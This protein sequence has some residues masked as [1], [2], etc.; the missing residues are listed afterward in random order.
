MLTL[1]N[2][3]TQT[4]EPFTASGKVALYVCGVT[5]YDTTHV[6]HA[7]VNVVFDVLVR[8]LHHR[9]I[10]ISYVQN[11]TDVDDSILQRAAELDVPYDELGDLYTS[12]YFDDLSALGMLPAHS[13]PRATEAMEQMKAVIA[14]L[15]A[16]GHAYRVDGDV[17]FRVASKPTYGELS[18]LSRH[19]MAEVERKQDA[20]TIDD[21]R[22]EDP[23]DFPLW[24][25][26]RPG[27]PSWDS[28]WGRGR[29]G[30]HIECTTLV[31]NNLGRQ[32]DIHGGGDDLIYPHHENEIAQSEAATGARPFAR[33]WVHVAMVRLGGEK[34]SKSG[35]N[36]VFVR[37]L[38]KRHSPDALRLYLLSTH[39]RDPLDFDESAL[40]R[41]GERAKKLA[42]AARIAPK[43]SGAKTIA[44][45]ATA[46]RF[47]TAIDDDLDTPAAVDELSRLADELLRVG[48]GAATY[49]ARAS[50]RALAGR[51][52]LSLEPSR[53]E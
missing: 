12:V 7:R 29:P 6:G 40:S 14:K 50:L 16:S 23:L 27:E 26:A 5:P 17:Y 53:R 8:H 42:A 48:P 11:V 2:T 19:E 20:T 21:P 38:L 51:L 45:D 47:D 15:L 25:S 31:L 39:Y 4:K 3:L 34:M 41:Y 49:T 13:Y 33:C 46:A 22:K 30:W 18:R 1:F 44:A 28:P 35:K 43:W 37:D 9:K 32:I 52:G 36:M 24:Q 10:D